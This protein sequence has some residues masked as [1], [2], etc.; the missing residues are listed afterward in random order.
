MRKSKILALAFGLTLAASQV[1]AQ[2]FTDDFI[3]R[4]EAEGYTEFVITRTWLGRTRLLARNGSIIRE[5]IF[6]TRSGEILRDFWDDDADGSGFGSHV[7]SLFD[8][9]D[10][11]GGSAASAL[12]SAGSDQSDDDT[13]SESSETSDG[14]SNDDASSS[15]ASS[16][17]DDA[18]APGDGSQ[19]FL[20]PS[21]DYL[22]GGHGNDVDFA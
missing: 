15:D 3:A 19:A 22:T 9:S 13:S 1:F 21:F 7:T 14:S 16:S 4:L 20:S 12:G 5:I 11:I 18:S 8:G 6:N 17:N 10:V 2:S